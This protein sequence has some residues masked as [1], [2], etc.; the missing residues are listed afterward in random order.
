QQPVLLRASAC[1]LDP[2]RWLENASR[3][4]VEKSG[5]YRVW[6]RRP[7]SNS[8]RSAARKTIASDPGILLGY[9]RDFLQMYKPGANIF[10]RGPL[11]PAVNQPWD[12]LR[13]LGRESTKSCENQ[14]LAWR[15]IFGKTYQTQSRRAA[16][17]LSVLGRVKRIKPKKAVLTSDKVCGLL[18]WMIRT[19]RKY[20]GG[21]E[22]T[23][24]QTASSKGCPELRRMSGIVSGETHRPD[25]WMEEF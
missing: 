1:S 16:A 4:R 24:G 5:T 8:F 10:D 3:L 21:R 25:H 2:I 7:A 18:Q 13:R 17:Y 22:T 6:D 14:T 11:M 15:V 23:P 12:R 20:R 9:I 19:I